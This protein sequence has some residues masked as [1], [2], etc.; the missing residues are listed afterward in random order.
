MERY[1]IDD[2]HSRTFSVP[3]WLIQGYSS[4]LF[5]LL[6][7]LEYLF[8]PTIG[9]I[10]WSLWAISKWWQGRAGIQLKEI[11]DVY[12]N[13]QSI[14]TFHHLPNIAGTSLFL[15]LDQSMDIDGIVHS[16]LDFQAV[17]HGNPVT[18]TSA[19]RQASWGKCFN[20]EPWVN[21]ASKTKVRSYRRPGGKH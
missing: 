6:Q 11:S 20:T 21:K 2:V 16:P 1:S 15:T 7:V 5:L 13:R 4:G 9:W 18:V 19:R 14:D 17:T 12:G 8:G 10:G 3:G